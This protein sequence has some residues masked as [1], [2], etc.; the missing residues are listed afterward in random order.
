MYSR[1][2]KAFHQTSTI[3]CD[4]GD[5]G[6]TP[7]SL[8]VLVSLRVI[9]L[10]RLDCI[11]GKCAASTQTPGYTSTWTES[12]KLL[13][14][15][16]QVWP[17]IL[18]LDLFSQFGRMVNYGFQEQNM[19]KLIRYLPLVC[20]IAYQPR[21]YQGKSRTNQP[22][23]RLSMA[24]LTHRSKSSARVS[25]GQPKSVTQSS[26]RKR[27]LTSCRRIFWP[28]APLDN[29]TVPYSTEIFEDLWFKEEIRQG[30]ERVGR[31]FGEDRFQMR[32]GRR[33]G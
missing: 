32:L 12:K 20:H 26:G 29:I 28:S 31:V 1:K 5:L 30:Q 6:S 4:P 7:L 27:K 19:T 23:V 17:S 25:Q 24:N 16:E 11:R 10:C 9:Y 21:G 13:V 8:I 15:F 33:C 14:N 18:N 22:L 2:K 3:R